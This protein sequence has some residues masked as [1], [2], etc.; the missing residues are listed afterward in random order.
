MMNLDPKQMSFLIVDDMDN[1]RRS[2]RAMLKL[3]N[4]GKNHYE[5]CNG[6]EAWAFLCTEK[7][8]VDFVISDWNMPKTNGTELLN[9]IRSSKKW[10]DLPFLMITAETNQ[11]IVAEAAENEVDAYMSKPF[12]TATLEVKIKELMNQVAHP[13]PLAQ[14]LKKGEE[15]SDKNQI[16]QA[17]ECLSLAV[18][19]NSRSSKPLR[20][21]GRLYL[22][23]DAIDQARTCFQQAIEINRLDLPSYQYLGQIA[24]KKGETEKALTFFMRALD[25][26]PR[27]ADRAFKVATLLLGQKKLA[28]AEKI[29][30]V[31]LR[32]NHDDLD[33]A[34]QAA[35]MCM[36]HGLYELAAKTY[37]AV[38]NADS[39]RQFLAKRLGQALQKDGHPKE[40][41]DVYEKSATKFPN[42]IELLLALAQ[43]Y[44]DLGLTMRAD[45]WASRAR[46]LDPKNEV[47]RTI[48][49]KCL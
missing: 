2:I 19:S 27:N 30:K 5:A 26:S 46:R 10:K 45:Q 29:L 42:D 23:K 40:A 14:L 39:E 9:L 12:V 32:N 34:V 1:M 48:L 44:L 31:M 43:A 49:N 36:E 41:I 24:L 25:L 8:H 16:D 3:I 35:D 38:I 28:E 47:A 13:S 37:R 17:I 15:F 21:L 33:L 4:F 7:V 20:E 11:S 6:K 18:K 22:K